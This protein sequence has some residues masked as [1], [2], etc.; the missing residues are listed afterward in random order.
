MGRHLGAAVLLCLVAQHACHA[1]CE[2]EACFED[3][4]C[5]DRACTEVDPEMATHGRFE[6][7]SG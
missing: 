6:S 7:C 5:E 3:G 1:E 2:A 4:H